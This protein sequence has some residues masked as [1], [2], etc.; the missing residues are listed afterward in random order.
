HLRFN[1]REIASYELSN[2]IMASDSI[3]SN[4]TTADNAAK[5]TF[6]TFTDIAALYL[7]VIGTNSMLI[8]ELF[9]KH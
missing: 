1:L 8:L 6:T 2:I 7:P 5:I 3:L 9:D 4:N